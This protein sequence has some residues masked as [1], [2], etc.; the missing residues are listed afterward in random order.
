ML[1]EG[2]NSGSMVLCFGLFQ[3]PIV[4]ETVLLQETAPGDCGC[5][6][7][8]ASPDYPHVCVHSKM[9]KKLSAT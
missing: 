9:V 5:V 7:R 3:D 4:G 1:H 8:H 2:V 6:G